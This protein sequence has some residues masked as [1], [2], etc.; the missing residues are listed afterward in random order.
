[1]TKPKEHHP[2]QLVEL[3]RRTAHRAYFWRPVTDTRELFGYPYAKAVKD[4]GQ[5]PHVA[6]LMSNHPHLLQT[7][8][9]GRRSDFMQQLNSNTG[10]KRNL[11]LNRRENL[12]ASGEPGDM[13]VLD[14][15]ETIKRVL[16]VALQPV[17]AG[18]VER[19]RDWTGF[20]ILPRHW[21]TPM[22]FERPELCGRDMP[23]VVEFTPMPPP[24]F[25]HL[26]LEQVI[27]FFE[28][29]L[30]QEERRYAKKR[31]RRVTFDSRVQFEF[32][33]RTRPDAHVRLTKR[34]S[35]VRGHGF[36]WP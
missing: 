9:T 27:A 20:H 21:G 15:E 19:V 8:T 14:I 7:D 16:Y 30:T 17:A 32:D 13:V 33:G 35:S 12:W 26:R 22:S 6:C 29:L 5:Q 28:G 25:D 2:G 3:S 23:E 11:Q 18:C 31:R 36:C 24:G 4:C 34:R 10:R 1:M